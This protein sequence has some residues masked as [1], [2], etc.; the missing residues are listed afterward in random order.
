MF[1]VP[2][3]INKYQGGNSCQFY[4]TRPAIL[5]IQWCHPLYT[6][7]SQSFLMSYCPDWGSGQCCVRVACLLPLYV[8]HGFRSEC[9]HDH[10]TVWI[11]C[12][13]EPKGPGGW[14]MLTRLGPS[15]IHHADLP[16]TIHHAD[17]QGSAHERP[18]VCQVFQYTVYFIS[19]SFS[20][21]HEGSHSK[22][23][24]YQPLMIT[25]QVVSVIIFISI[26]IQLKV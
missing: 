21:C 11:G 10:C 17:F 3:S 26:I 2:L 15:T 13:V 22:Q 25:S 19:L 20:S 18:Q 4:H 8:L 14:P 5:V 6:P 12:N 7:W 1:W 9:S 16:S 23:E 24:I